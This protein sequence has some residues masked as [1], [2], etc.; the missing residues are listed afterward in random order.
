M[1]G[2]W[3]TLPPLLLL[4]PVSSAQETHGHLSSEQ[5]GKVSFQTS[6]APAVQ[7]QFDRGVALLHSFAYSSAR[8]AFQ[9][10]AEMDPGCA[11]AHWGIAFSYYHQLWNPP[12]V[13]STVPIAQQEIQRAQ[14]IGRN[15]TRARVHR[16]P[17]PDI[18]GCCYRS[19]SHASVELR[20]CDE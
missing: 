1:L 16:R 8:D 12:L 19:L 10:V 7:K 20:A 14:E 2:L 9:R 6:C 18:Q 17:K 4:I 11:M 13:P 5:L 15:A 3:R